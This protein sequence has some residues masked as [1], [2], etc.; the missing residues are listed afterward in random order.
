[1]LVRRRSQSVRPGSW[2]SILKNLI[3]QR[4]SFT[5]SAAAAWST[6]FGCPRFESK[7]HGSQGHEDVAPPANGFH[8]KQRKSFRAWQPSIPGW[9]PPRRWRRRD[10]ALNLDSPPVGHEQKPRSPATE[11]IRCRTARRYMR[12]GQGNLWTKRSVI[13]NNFSTQKGIEAAEGRL[14]RIKAEAKWLVLRRIAGSPRPPMPS[15]LGRRI[16]ALHKLLST[17][18]T[19]KFEPRSEPC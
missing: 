1:M 10:S 9:V 11:T 18:A 14:R 5:G 15:E 17:T 8:E 16:G 12:N 4:N 19:G 6:G 7:Q 13:G 2:S 3:I